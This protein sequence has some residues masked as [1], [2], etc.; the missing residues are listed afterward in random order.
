LRKDFLS[1]PLQGDVVSTGNI[2]LKITKTTNKRTG[3]VTVAHE[4]MGVITK[5]IRFRQLADYQ[6][7]PNPLDSLVQLRMSLEDWNVQKLEAFRM[8]HE[9]GLVDDLRNM[10]PPIFTTTEWSLP[11]HYKQNPAVCKVM[12]KDN[13][14]I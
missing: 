12:I 6:Y 8:S 4:I 14:V 5:T 2:L 7:H 11:Y 10:P 9:T 3:Q 13:E 1:H